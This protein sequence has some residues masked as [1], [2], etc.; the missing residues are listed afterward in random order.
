[1]YTLEQ[2]REQLQSRDNSMYTLNERDN[3]MY[4]LN[5]LV[6]EIISI[7][8]LNQDDEQVHVQVSKLIKETLLDPT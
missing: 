1:M 5:E 8:R 3:S 6:S 7:V 4:T 2:I